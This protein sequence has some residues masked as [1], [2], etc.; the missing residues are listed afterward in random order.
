MTALLAASPTFIRNAAY[1]PVDG[2]NDG[3]QGVLTSSS[4]TSSAAAPRLPRSELP[5]R[6]AT[7]QSRWRSSRRRKRMI[8]AEALL[9]DNNLTRRRT[10]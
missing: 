1:D 7:V 4:T 6:G 10:G 2:P 3:M 9:S 5:N 8:I